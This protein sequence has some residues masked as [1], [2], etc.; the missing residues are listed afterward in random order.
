M[1]Y[2][3][4]DRPNR[5]HVGKNWNSYHL[6]SLQLILQATHG[7][8]SG[9]PD[10]FKQAFGNTYDEFEEIISRPHH[11]IFNRF[12]YE[13]FDGKPEL[14][15]YK[16]L[17]ACLSKQEK[18]ELLAFLSAHDQKTYKQ[19]HTTISNEKVR[20]IAQYYIP[21]HK[22]EERRIWD[23]KKRCPN[24]AP[25][26]SITISKDEIVE[27]AGLEDQ[28]VGILNITNSIQKVAIA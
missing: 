8:V 10:F 18:E 1:R 26:D 11:F 16:K 23:A 6:R 19:K 15:A 17:Y 24:E 5:G 27:D 22:D 20:E 3:P 14:D 2:Q 25:E 21:L 13:Y 4:I 9:A 12:W 28:E 7:I